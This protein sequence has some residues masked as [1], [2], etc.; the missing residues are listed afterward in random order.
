MSDAI[1][2]QAVIEQL[3]GE[4][5]RLREKLLK[6]RLDGF[7]PFEGLLQWWEGLD[8]HEKYIMVAGACMVL[9][10]MITLIRLVWR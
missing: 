9:I 1:D 2:Y 6:A 4:N 8:F 10:T 3:Q 5:E 7:M